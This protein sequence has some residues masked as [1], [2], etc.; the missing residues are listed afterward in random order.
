MQYLQFTARNNN[1]Q[2][3]HLKETQ[4][5]SLVTYEWLTIVF[6]FDQRSC[7]SHAECGTRI[8]SLIREIR[9]LDFVK[10]GSFSRQKVEANEISSF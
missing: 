10:P 2:N 9:L 6:W 5:K 1:P 8:K 7:F 3:L 4:G